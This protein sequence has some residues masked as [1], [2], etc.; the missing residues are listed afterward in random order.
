[1]LSAPTYESGS[2][3]YSR[4]DTQHVGHVQVNGAVGHP[5]ELCPGAL[6]VCQGILIKGVTRVRL[7]HDP[8]PSE[9]LIDNS[10]TKVVFL[11]KSS[12]LKN[13]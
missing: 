1:M 12:F 13:P 11:H 8:P 9:D 7:L 4:R 10:E 6:S 5:G 2:E 3:R